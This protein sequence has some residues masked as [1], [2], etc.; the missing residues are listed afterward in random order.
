MLASKKEIPALSGYSIIGKFAVESTLIVGEFG[1]GS[2]F[3]ALSGVWF[4]YF[5]PA[6]EQTEK[7]TLFAI[8]SD[9]CLRRDLEYVARAT[10]PIDGASMA[11]VEALAMRDKGF[12]E[13]LETAGEG[14]IKNFGVK[15]TLDGDGTANVCTCEADGKVVAIEVRM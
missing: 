5:C 6:N 1:Y 4:A 3:A 15:V 10:L 12:R 2:E 7:D 9:Y 13:K 8:H 11:V 14:V